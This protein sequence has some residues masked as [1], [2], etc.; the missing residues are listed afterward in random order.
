ME[1]FL[2]VLN[3]ELRAKLAVSSTATL[4][5]CLFKRGLRNQVIQD[6]HLLN[7]AAPTMVGFAY[8]LRYIPARE[9]ID[10]VEAFRDAGHPQRAGDRGVSRRAPSSSSTAARMR[11]PPRRGRSW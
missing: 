7:P 10:R 11:A 5:T 4:S 3:H 9:D 6:V 2:V 1:G 8:T